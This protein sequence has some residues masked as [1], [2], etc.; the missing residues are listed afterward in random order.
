MIIQNN[1]PWA[2]PLSTCQT[3]VCTIE[4]MIPTT[5]YWQE[6]GVSVI[7]I[8]VKVLLQRSLVERKLQ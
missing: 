2:S 4:C 7:A 1:S 6:A 8:A 5:L 3:E